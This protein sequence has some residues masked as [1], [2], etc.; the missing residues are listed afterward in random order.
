VVAELVR[1]KPDGAKDGDLAF[2]GLV[3]RSKRF[4]ALLKAAG[5]PKKDTQGRVADF[6]SLRHTFC[7]YLQ[8]AGVSQR[9]AMELMRHNDPRLTASTYTDTRLLGLRSAVGKLSIGDS[10]RDSQKLVPSGHSVSSPVTIGSV[11]NH[12]Q[13][14]DNK[15][16]KSLPVTIVTTCQNLGYGA[17]CRV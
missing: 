12:P 3:P 10:Q 2:K 11:S 15:G 13:P 14:V 4:N 8:R 9:E 16:L 5:I 7:T 6:H 17:H 1:L